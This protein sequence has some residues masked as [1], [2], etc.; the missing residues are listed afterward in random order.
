MNLSFNTNEKAQY[1]TGVN[2]KRFGRVRRMY[3][4]GCTF[5]STLDK[6]NGV[7]TIELKTKDKFLMTKMVR[8]MADNIENT[9]IIVKGY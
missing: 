4:N 1:K 9:D 6:Q 3:G 8:G 5:S 2:L 7:C